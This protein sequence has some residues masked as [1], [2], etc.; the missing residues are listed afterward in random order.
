[1][2]ILFTPYN[3]LISNAYRKHLKVTWSNSVLIFDE[4]HNLVSLEYRYTAHVNIIIF[5][6]FFPAE[7][8]SLSLIIRAG[9][10]MRRLS[11]I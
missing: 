7:R 2:D 6:F 9:R 11:F 4:A 3:Y 8:L 10:F 5:I 1:M